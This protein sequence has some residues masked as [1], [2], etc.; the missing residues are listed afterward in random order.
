MESSESLRPEWQH[1]FYML[2]DRM[3]SASLD[4]VYFLVGDSPVK[5]WMFRR[6]SA[7]TFLVILCNR[8][9]H[10]WCS[11][12]PARPPTPT[13]TLCLFH[14]IRVDGSTAKE[15]V[16]LVGSQDDLITQAV[17]ILL[18]SDGLQPY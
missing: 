6:I 1:L 8:R 15:Y 11:N 10:A 13:G 2:I 5:L 16:G 4:V 7:S 17:S 18:N 14:V 3:Q 9:F 12:F